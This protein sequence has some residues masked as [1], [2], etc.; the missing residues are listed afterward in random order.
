M[1]PAPAGRTA[2]CWVLVAVGTALRL[3]ARAAPRADPSERDYRTGLLPWVRASNR[4]LGHGCMIRA[5]GSHRVARRSMRF[6]FR[7]VRWLR[8]RSAL[9]Q[10]LVAW[11]RNAL[12]ASLLPGTA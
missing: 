3:V 2:L 4:T 12:T 7:R 8:R 9:C 1:A 6:Q 11:V 5:G 10:C